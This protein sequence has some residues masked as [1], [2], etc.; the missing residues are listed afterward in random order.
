MKPD[1]KD[2]RVR[3]FW[4]SALILLAVAS[5]AGYILSFITDISF[6]NL[7][8][9]EGILFLIVA[10]VPIFSEVG[11]NARTSFRAR[12]EGKEVREAIQQQQASGRY[13]KGTRITFLYGICGFICFILAVLTL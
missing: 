12:R 5:A 2:D 7:Y 10:V 13:S 11:G 6:S 4:L 8:F 3:P 1:R 9:V